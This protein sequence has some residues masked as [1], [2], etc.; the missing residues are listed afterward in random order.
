MAF[1]GSG[2]QKN[3]GW[4]IVPQIGLSFSTVFL[5]PRK[6]EFKLKKSRGEGE[7]QG[8]GTREGW[9]APCQVA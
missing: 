2:K 5:D 3:G 6:G 8:E 9:K 1:A 7:L 4:G